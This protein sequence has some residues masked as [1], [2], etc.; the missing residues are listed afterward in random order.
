[1][2]VLELRAG[3]VEGV[4]LCWTGATKTMVLGMGAG[5]CA[6]PRLQNTTDLPHSNHHHHHRRHHHHQ[7]L[8]RFELRRR[9]RSRGEEGGQEEEGRVK[10][11]F[12]LREDS[13]RQRKCESFSTGFNNRSRA[14][15]EL[16]NA[17][18]Q[19]RGVRVVV[20][21]QHLTVMRRRLEARRVLE[22]PLLVGR[23]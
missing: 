16:L 13:M 9:G 17:M 23:G 22:N 10:W 2:E 7:G 5:V 19:H 21:V 14:P 1:M 11:G 8:K 4:T 6:R 18:C 20:V 12:K 15:Q 3:L